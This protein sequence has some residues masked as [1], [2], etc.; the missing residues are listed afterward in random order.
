MGLLL[1]ALRVGKTKVHPLL[2]L[3]LQP[4]TDDMVPFNQTSK[5]HTDLASES[6][7]P[8]LHTDPTVLCVRKTMKLVFTAGLYVSNGYQL[9][10]TAGLC[11]S[12]TI[13]HA[14]DPNHSPGMY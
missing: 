4:C 7:T 14:T 6:Q 10:A 13:I 11:C 2:C 9:L 12:Y 5:Y 3:Q 1:L 8:R